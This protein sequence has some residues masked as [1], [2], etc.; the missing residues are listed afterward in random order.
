[1]ASDNRAVIYHIAVWFTLCIFV[2]LMTWIF[3]SGA[4][5]FGGALP[6]PIL[7]NPPLVFASLA[8]FVVS[9][10]IL[11]YFKLRTGIISPLPLGMAGL[12]AIA[13]FGLAIVSASPGLGSVV[14]KDFIA[15]DVGTDAPPRF[16][17]TILFENSSDALTPYAKRQIEDL[18]VVFASCQAPNAIVRGFASSARFRENSDDQNRNLAN[19]RANSVSAF[20]KERGVIVNKVEWISHEDMANQLRIIDEKDGERILAREPSNRR[21]EVLWDQSPCGSLGRPVIAATQ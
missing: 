8:L 17:V 10:V 16:G 18:L 21:V 7:V 12:A 15:G 9:G 4:V 11:L 3:K 2:S 6:K 1:M 14:A 5:E 20:L 19:R 13:S